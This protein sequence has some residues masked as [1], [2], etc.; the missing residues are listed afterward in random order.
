MIDI[1]LD[2]SP[3]ELLVA[4]VVVAALAVALLRR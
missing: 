1:L 3:A 4:A 2:R